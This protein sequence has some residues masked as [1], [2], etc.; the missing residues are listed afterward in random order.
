MSPLQK[1][2]ARLLKDL[3]K[4]TYGVNRNF[5]FFH[6]SSILQSRPDIFN[7]R[8]LLYTLKVTARRFDIYGNHPTADLWGRAPAQLGWVGW[9]STNKGRFCKGQSMRAATGSLEEKVLPLFRYWLDSRGHFFQC[10]LQILAGTRFWGQIFCFHVKRSFRWIPRNLVTES[11]RLKLR[12]SLRLN[13]GWSINIWVKI[14]QSR[15]SESSPVQSSRSKSSKSTTGPR[16]WSRLRF[17]QNST[18]ISD[19]DVQKLGN[20][21]CYSSESIAAKVRYQIRHKWKAMSESYLETCLDWTSVD[22]R[23]K[24]FF[25]NQPLKIIIYCVTDQPSRARFR[26]SFSLFCWNVSREKYLNSNYVEC[27]NMCRSKVCGQELWY[28]LSLTWT[29]WTQ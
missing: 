24:D 15:C 14:R 23:F 27:D 17:Q 3:G 20:D 1:I 16:K 18:T 22:F 5:D 12:S 26:R 9:A 6:P 7:V 8:Y 2:H 21:L 25:C 19:G 13:F 28:I 4:S 11:Y 29:W 10:A